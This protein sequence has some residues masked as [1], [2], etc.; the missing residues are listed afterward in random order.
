MD[1]MTAADCLYGPDPIE[2]QTGTTLLSLGHD[3][4]DKTKVAA[5]SNHDPEAVLY[6]GEPRQAAKEVEPRSE[7]S[8]QAG[9]RIKDTLYGGDGDVPDL[10]IPGDI[11]DARNADTA[12]SL[13][14]PQVTFGKV[15]PE[16]I[17][18]GDA[19]VAKLSAGMQRA[20]VAEVREIAQDLGMTTDDVLA[21][22][23]V[24]QRCNSPVTDATRQEW[25]AEATRRLTEIY[26]ADTQTAYQDAMNF[27]RRDP[28]FA[29]AIE[30][31]GR[32]DH[33]DAVVLFAKLAKQA[34][35]AGGLK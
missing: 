26:G 22:R 20:V 1:N 6:G 16:T 27:V 8:D 19:E 2:P 5:E 31:G 21:L 23:S 10:A 12:R 18:E 15:I 14:S 29:K 24:G 3:G 17:F 30:H 13:Y 7:T 11:K 25:R 34:K 32:A 4:L 33:P 28:R 35:A 9:E